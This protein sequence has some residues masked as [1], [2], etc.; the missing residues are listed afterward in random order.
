MLLDTGSQRTYVTEKLAKA[1][2]LQLNTPERLAVVTFGSNRPKYLQYTPS[3]L[4]LILRQGKPMILDV[5]VVPNITGKITQTLLCKDDMAFLES[6]GFENKLADVPPTKSDTYLIEMLIG[7]DY[8]FNLLLPRKVDLRPGLWLLQSKLGWALGGRC[9]TENETV[10][11]PTLLV[12]TVSIPPMGMRASTHML[13]TVDSSM[14]TYP[15]L[16]RF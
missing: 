9:H 11:E 7:N 16:D 10:E 15:N 2:N 14:L 13:T 5:S 3:K 4:Q 12:S 8:Y 1:L 6:E